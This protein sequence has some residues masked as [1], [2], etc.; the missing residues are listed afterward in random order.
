MPSGI[1]TVAAIDVFDAPATL[2]KD[3]ALSS[4]TSVHLSWSAVTPGTSPGGEILGYRLVVYDINT[5]SS[6][7]DFDG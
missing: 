7:T 3:T 1:L 5:G 2:T 6:W 4:L